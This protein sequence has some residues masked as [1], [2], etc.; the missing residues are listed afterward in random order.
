MIILFALVGNTSNAN[1]KVN[2][3]HEVLIQ[4]SGVIWGFDFLDSNRIIFTLRAGS[5]HVLDIKLKTSIEI[6]GAP[7]V[8]YKGQGGLLDI[9]VHPTRKD[10]IYLTYAKPVGNLSTTALAS[11]KILNNQLTNFKI[12]FSAH[13][14]NS[15]NIHYGSRVEFDGEN[16]LFMTIGDRNSRE[17]VQDLS[18]H[19]GKIIRL[20]LDGSIPSDNPF[21]GDKVAKPEIWSFGHRSPQGLVIHP[22]TGELWMSEMGPKGGDEVNIVK[23]GS[24]YGWPLI[25][26]GKEYYGLKIGEGTKKVGMEDPIAYWVPSISPSGMTIYQGEIFPKWKGNIFLGNLSGSHLRRLVSEGGKVIEQEV[27]LSELKMRIRNVRSGPDGYI[28][29]STDDGKIMRLIAN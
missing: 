14:E 15:N 5:I 1:S 7:Q 20:H 27:L 19:M 29:L 23:K 12:L 13:K 2:F 9:R 22:V 6:S 8:W 21:V 18:F 11:A 16:H 17:Q 25:T 26:Y 3:K 4:K 28:Y 10:E 24:N